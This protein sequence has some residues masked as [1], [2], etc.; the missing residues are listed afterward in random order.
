MK[1]RLLSLL[2]AVMMLLSILPMGVSASTPVH[3]MTGAPSEP[4]L[5]MHVL[6]RND[7]NEQ[8]YVTNDW[9]YPV[10]DWWDARF[11]MYYPDGS[12]KEINPYDMGRTSEID[13]IEVG[14]DGWAEHRTAHV[15]PGIIEYEENGVTYRVHVEVT[16]PDLGIYSDMPFD[17]S[18]LVDPVTVD[19]TDNVFY[20]ALS[21]TMTAAG[22]YMK[23]IVFVDEPNR[24]PDISTVADVQIAADRSYAKVTV[25]AA[26]PQGK[27]HFRVRIEN[28][29]GG[30]RGG[31][32]RGVQIVSDMPALY[33]CYADRDDD[34]RSWFIQYED[35]DDEWHTT[36]GYNK[37]GSFYFGK[38]SEIMAGKVKPLG[39]KDLTFLGDLEAEY[40]EDDYEATPNLLIVDAVGFEGKYI[41]YTKDG[42]NYDMPIYMELPKFGFYTGDTPDED[43]FIYRQN[44]LT[45]TETAR[46]FYLLSRDTDEFRFRSIRGWDEL[47]QN[48][49]IFDISVASDGSGVKLT[50]KDGVIVPN[51]QIWIEYEYEVFRNDNWERRTSDAAVWLKNGQPALMFRSLHWDDRKQEWYEPEDRQLQTYMDVNTGDGF[52]VQFYYGTEDKKVKVDFDELTFPAGI[53]R[54]YM[55]NDDDVLRIDAVG[56]AENGVITYENADG[57]LI[58]MQ[59][60]VHAPRFGLYSSLTANKSTYLGDE[61]TLGGNYTAYIIAADPDDQYITAIENVRCT[62]NGSD[63]TNQFVFNVAPDG[64]YA[65]VSLNP[66]DMPM[67]NQHYEIRIRNQWGGNWHVWF[68]LERG[69]LIQLTTPTD[70][71]WHVTYGFHWDENDNYVPYTDKRMGMMSFQVREQNGKEPLTQNEFQIEVYSAADGYTTPVADGRWGWGDMEERTHFSISEFIYEDLPSG[72]YKFR[73]RNVGDGTKYRSSAWS[74]WSPVFEYIQ[75]TTRLEAPEAD[76]LEWQIIRDRQAA[77]WSSESGY[78]DGAGYFELKW[79]YLDENGIIRETGGSFDIWVNREDQFEFYD[80]HIQDWILEDHGNTEYYFTVRVIPADITKYRMSKE[81]PL[82]P[83]LKVEDITIVMNNKLDGLLNGSNDGSQPAPTVQD[84]QDALQQDTADL[85]TAMAADL[86]VNGGQNSGTLDRIAQLEAA[87]SDNVDQKIEAKNSAPQALKD[88]ASGVTMVGATL[89]LADKN[90]DNGKTPTV[91]LEIDEPK[92]GIVIDEQQHNAVQ[93]SMKLNGA[94]N[95]DDQN[96]AQQ[97]LIVPVVIDMP[98]PSGIN[99]HFLVVLHKLWD[100]RVEQMWPHIY[101]HETDHCWHARFVID[102]FSDFAFVEYDFRFETDGDVFKSEG[103]P[104]FTIEAVGAAE[105]A[106]VWYESSNPRIADVDPRTGE[107]TIHKTGTVII[108]ATAS[109]VGNYPEATAAYTLFIEGEDGADAEPVYNIGDITLLDENGNEVD[110]F[111]E[112]V[113]DAVVTVENLDASDDA[114]LLAALYTAE[115]QYIGMQTVSIEDIQRGDSGEITLSIDN[116]EGNVATL[117]TFV[118]ASDDNMTP[119][120]NTAAVGAEEPIVTPTEIYKAYYTGEPIEMQNGQACI[121]IYCNG[122]QYWL[123]WSEEVEITDDM[124]AGIYLIEVDDSDDVI[125]TRM[126]LFREEAGNTAVI[127]ALGEDYFRIEGSDS[128]FYVGD[129]A[130]AYDMTEGGAQANDIEVGDTIIWYSEPGVAIEVIWILSHKTE[131]SKS[132]LLPTNLHLEYDPEMGLNLFMTKSAYP[133]LIDGNISFVYDFKESGKTMSRNIGKN[134]GM[135]QLLPNYSYL[136]DGNNTITVTLTANPTAAAA[137]MGY[138]QETATYTFNVSQ[139]KGVS[140]YDTSKIEASIKD[141]E[142]D[143]GQAMKSMVITGLKANQD[144]TIMV[145]TNDGTYNKRE[146][147]TDPSGTATDLWYSAYDFNHCVI[148]EWNVSGVT[149]TSATIT[150]VSYPGQYPFV[151]EEEACADVWFTTS[152]SGKYATYTVNWT[153][154]ELASNENYYLNGERVIT[155]TAPNRKDIFNSAVYPFDVSTMDIAIEKGVYNGERTVLYTAKNAFRTNVLAK[156]DFTV[157]GQADGTY[158]LKSD[159]DLTGMNYYV[160]V[161]DADGTVLFSSVYETPYMDLYPWDGCTL[162]VVAGYFELSEDAHILTFTHVPQQAITTFDRPD[163]PADVTVTTADQLKAALKL[164]GRVTL[165][166]DITLTGYLTIN[167]GEPVTLVLNGH[168]L[169]T[170][171]G[172]T[173]DYGKQVTIDG[174]ATGSTVVGKLTVKNGPKLMV[175]GGDYDHITA[176]R[177]ASVVMRNANVSSDLSEHAIYI[178][179]CD[180]TEL[181]N[182]TASASTRSALYALQSGTLTVDGGSYTTTASG[183]SYNGI[184]TSYVDGVVL[185]DVTAEAAGGHAGMVG[186]GTDV[187]VC[188]GTFTNTS[189]GKD[190]LRIF[191]FDYA[192]IGG[193]DEADL[194]VISPYRG[195]E[196]SADNNM[197]LRN[198]TAGGPDGGYCSDYGIKVGSGS[199]TEPLTASLVNLTARASKTAL[200]TAPIADLTIENCTFIADPSA[201]DSKGMDIGG[202]ITD[203]NLLIRNTA[204][205]GQ[206]G[207]YL[208]NYEEAELQDLTLTGSLQSLYATGIVQLNVRGGTMNGEVHFGHQSYM[209][210]EAILMENATVNGRL[211]IYGGSTNKETQSVTVKSGSFTLPESATEA[212]IYLGQYVELNI[213]GGT[214]LLPDGAAVEMFSLNKYATGIE[215][216]GGTFNEDPSAYVLTGYTAELQNGMWTVAADAAYTMDV[217]PSGNTANLYVRGTFAEG[218][219][220][221]EVYRNGTEYIGDAN[222][223]YTWGDTHNYYF[224]NPDGTDST[225]LFKLVGDGVTLVT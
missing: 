2:L 222:C 40:L 115:G 175:N 89:N 195:L 198:I 216:T 28:D 212:M 96:Q 136:T 59:V 16:Y 203:T 26:Q 32:G 160:R 3:G 49:D 38:R 120:G 196:V 208:F 169:N 56:Y 73:V 126:D 199:H 159:S 90:P 204:A 91:T 147:T 174:T 71:E 78:Q 225:F 143:E 154:V 14:S 134:T 53:V 168:T 15:G 202:N 50:V 124:P 62:S 93:F 149:D 111:A 7:G 46:T 213:E 35:I 45:V 66:N 206:F 97:Q 68:R 210:P 87:V 161:K 217:Q 162:E 65:T 21:P 74:E 184:Y 123:P 27:Y 182:C 180:T 133:E 105:G 144:Y 214:F 117:K 116:S 39:L 37:V 215:I 170:G 191:G 30:P 63:A 190:A 113:F 194:Q 42:V 80:H 132:G 135:T 58:T 157:V 34:T 185:N 24:A 12:T 25:T 224:T 48:G 119:M 118:V 121:S 128:N 176:N 193:T 205:S 94:V 5:R 67:G 197:T 151:G 141:T 44:P 158:M 131:A 129:N 61:V 107:V 110:E 70:L 186:Y 20:I 150:L 92:Q 13:L 183:T 125:L 173:F 83:A 88:I 152:G 137:E 139:T 1:K 166:S 43:T 79:Y 140:D 108:T 10:D 31:W 138:A 23:E 57:E 122:D 179:Y 218:T 99:P 85:R 207:L 148:S 51:D 64:S 219:P 189:T 47:A 11:F 201:A 178:V 95:H 36:P 100:G 33:F 76:D 4:E 106:E 19:D 171:S 172:L 188:G 187:T 22:S 209:A 41:R 142:D 223:N 84:V 75:P 52:P 60:S 200:D 155:S 29:E 102:S 86:S 72:K 98:V 8:I 181:V 153:A 130:Y 103:D 114:A 127:S 69:D 220:R 167:G 55:D 104:S 221:V 146:L 165:G 177:L 164:G 17:E 145:W 109:A 9:S 81:S 163:A 82:S 54:G 156:A 77:T 112:G 6:Q 211:H 101:W 18:T 192:N